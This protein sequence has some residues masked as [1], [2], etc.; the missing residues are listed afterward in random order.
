MKAPKNPKESLTAA[1]P[2]DVCLA[3]TL[4]V[5]GGGKGWTRTDTFM[6]L[7]HCPFPQIK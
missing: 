7:K 1:E 5:G 2:W 4:E 3:E 6:P